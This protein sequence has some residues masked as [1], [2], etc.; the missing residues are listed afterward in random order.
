MQTGSSNIYLLILAGMLFSFLIAGA[1]ILFYTR[2]HR[3]LSEQQ[4]RIREA[5]LQHQKDILHA[6]IQSQEDE[7]KRIGQDLHDDVGSVLSKLRL[8]LNQQK[9]NGTANEHQHIQFLIDRAIDSTRNISHRLCPATLEFFGFADA[10]QE[11]CDTARHSSGIHIS[12][13]DG[14][15]DKTASISYQSSLHLFRV[16]EELITNTLKHSEATT[17][18]ICFR[19]KDDHL[20]CSYRDDGKGFDI[21]GTNKGIGLLNINSRMTMIGARH[22]I[23]TGPGRGVAADIYVPLLLNPKI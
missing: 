11:L 15:G 8:I 14:A 21:N 2:Y 22:S 5:E 13:D 19:E 20:Y 23:D 3:R 4:Q 10:I 1:V 6:T 9:N 12:L 18:A 17:V 7:R 16:F